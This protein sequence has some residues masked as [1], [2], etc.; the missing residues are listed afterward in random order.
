MNNHRFEIIKE[1]IT[2]K[3]VLDIG[4]VDHDFLDGKFYASN[5]SIFYKN[6]WL[7]RLIVNYSKSVVGIDVDKKGIDFL[8]EKGYN[9]KHANAQDFLLNEKFDCIVA[10]EIIEHLT[11]FEG[12]F[13]SIKNHMDKNSK[14]I[15]TTPN[16]FFF[17][18]PF[19]I[20]IS[21][22]PPVNPTHTCW[23]DEIT[24]NQLLQKFDLKIIKTFYTSD[25][26][27][28]RM[29]PLPNKLKNTTVCVVTQLK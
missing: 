8:K 26:K 19:K 23:F 28:Y 29:L 5:N 1:Y 27:R 7:H 17:R 22:K 11:N 14:L 3:K 15:I 10:G 24:L 18:R 6:N 16:V 12:F 2:D 25:E 21:G 20:L 9:V 4:V 13:K